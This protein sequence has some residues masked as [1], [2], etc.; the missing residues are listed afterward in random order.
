M[1]FKR[2]HLEATKSVMNKIIMG[3]NERTISKSEK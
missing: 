1:E 3:Q 2:T